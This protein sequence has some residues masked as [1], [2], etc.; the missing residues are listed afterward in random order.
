[1]GESEREI[2]K[3]PT[4]ALFVITHN[5]PLTNAGGLPNVIT[6]ASTATP[7]FSRI[8]RKTAATRGDKNPR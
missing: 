2:R 7:Q 8:N 6:H 5:Q 1:L 4:T 3:L